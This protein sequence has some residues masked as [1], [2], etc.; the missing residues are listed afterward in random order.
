MGYAVS[1]RNNLDFSY[2]NA[3]ILHNTFPSYTD[4]RI[5]I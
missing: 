4:V 1:V 5:I 3:Y 2:L